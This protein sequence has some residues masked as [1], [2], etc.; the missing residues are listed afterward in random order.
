MKSGAKHLVTFYGMDVN[1]TPKQDPRWL[2]C[3]KSLFKSADM[4]LCEGSHMAQC[5]INMGCSRNKVNVQHLG[6]EV[7]KI[8]FKPRTWRR[9]EPLRVLIAASFREKKGIPYAL[10]ALGGCPRTRI[11]VIFRNS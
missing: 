10:E 5:L 11:F 1:M 7:E 9:G 2:W 6:V 3:Y 8:L 4:F